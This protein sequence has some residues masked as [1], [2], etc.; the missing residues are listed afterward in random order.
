MAQVGG[1]ISERTG[2]FGGAGGDSAIGG[3]SLAVRN[4]AGVGSDSF[5][6]NSAGRG[7]V[8]ADWLATASPGQP[9]HCLK[10]RHHRSC[11][12]FCRA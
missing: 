5:K 6:T 1:V 3:A 4:T 10:F 9:T 7:R 12:L 11:W 2:L 8:T